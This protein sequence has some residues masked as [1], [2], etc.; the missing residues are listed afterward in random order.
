MLHF[1]SVVASTH[2]NCSVAGAVVV[3]AA[4]AVVM[5]LVAQAQAAAAEAIATPSSAALLGLRRE[6]E[7]ALSRVMLETE[8]G[9][10][11]VVVGTRQKRVVAGAV[12]KRAVGRRA[13]DVKLP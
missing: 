2:V 13:V 1:C 9:T 4:A 3:A 12:D 5:V 7:G 8:E 10:A 6:H 11:A